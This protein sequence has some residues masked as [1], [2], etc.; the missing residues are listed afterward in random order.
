MAS[1]KH[2]LHCPKCNHTEF[3]EEKIVLLDSSVVIRKDLEVPGRT[4]RELYRYICMNCGELLDQPWTGHH[5]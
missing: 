3:R 2:V 5:D 1:E 4:V